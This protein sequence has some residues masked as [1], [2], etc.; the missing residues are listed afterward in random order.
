MSL[1]SWVT[2]T[3]AIRDA[4][5]ASTGQMG[6]VLFGLSIGSMTGILTAGPLVRRLGTRPVIAV[7][8]ALAISGLAVLGAATA[9]G[10][11]SVAFTG[12]LLFGA[13]MGCSEVAVNIEGAEVERQA[14]RPLMPLL[15]GTYS[16]GTVVGS[17]LG[18]VFAHIGTGVLWHLLVIAAA[19]I[20]IAAR[21][22]P[23]IPSGFGV[24]RAP[25]GRS[26]TT[27]MREQLAL[28]A[29]RRI[30]LIGCVVLGMALAEGSANDWLALLM[31]DAHG[32]S[33]ATGS[34]LYA[35]FATSM[36]AG[37]FA[38]EA[39]VSRFG[40][41]H[42]VRASALCVTLGVALVIFTAN[43]I[44]AVA[45][46]V[47]W[48]LGAALGFPLAI[49]AA[50]DG[51]GDTTS[52]VSAVATAGYLAFL[53]GP[54]MLGFLGDHFGLRHAM[55]VVLVLA[56]FAAATASAVRPP[57]RVTNPGDSGAP[58]HDPVPDAER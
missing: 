22:I 32:Y 20:V 49:S 1:A 53:V 31:V 19:A 25:S 33:P 28:W 18:L 51:G 47:L 24:Q 45:G 30:A 12:L 21:S 57:T 41:A 56:V 39:L 36:T 26:A 48:G 55:I 23:A 2:R 16:A 10:L 50:G 8:T 54:P 37:R 7:S 17:A 40:R 15:H 29:D 35:A 27:G 58:T 34:L 44:V 11:A 5:A 38:G 52:R 3:P 6:L 14:D 46:V 42:V 13:G 4:L 43:P 9:L